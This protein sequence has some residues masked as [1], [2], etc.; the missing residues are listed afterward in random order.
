MSGRQD[1]LE[2]RYPDNT[3]RYIWTPR[4]VRGKDVQIIQADISGRQDRLEE[5]ISR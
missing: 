4:Q 3:D 1:R 5:K 2:D